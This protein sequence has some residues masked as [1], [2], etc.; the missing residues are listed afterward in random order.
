MTALLLFR[1]GPGLLTLRNQSLPLYLMILCSSAQAF[2]KCALKDDEELSDLKGAF[3]SV[4]NLHVFALGAETKDLQTETAGVVESNTSFFLWPK[5]SLHWKGY[6]KGYYDT[7]K[8]SDAKTEL[9][10]VTDQGFLHFGHSLIDPIQLSIG[11]LPLP[12]GLHHEILRYQ[13]P[14]RNESF[15]DRSV[16]GAIVSWRFRKD[17]VIDVGGT[18]K[19]EEDL[20][21]REFSAFTIRATQHID[22][23]TGAKLIGSYQNTGGQSAGKMGLA[24]IVFNNDDV[25]S[26]EW[27]RIAENW[28]TLNYQ[29][30]FRFVYQARDKDKLYTFEYED[31]RRDSYRTGLSLAYQSTEDLIFGTA[32]QYERLRATG[33]S[34]WAYLLNLSYNLTLQSN[35]YRWNSDEN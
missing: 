1:K 9:V 12:F 31:L 3:C 34:N 24:T 2:G 13:L 33:D 29:Q 7:F 5:V 8:E 4:N 26:L 14:H 28:K 18:N 27:M 30:L 16:N 25:S 11:R 17:L 20:A 35:L 23:L 32:L 15:W 19:N 10:R 21:D 6:A 22:L